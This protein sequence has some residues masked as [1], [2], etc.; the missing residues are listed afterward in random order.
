MVDPVPSSID[1]HPTSPDE[2]AKSLAPT[3]AEHALKELGMKTA[4]EAVH[5]LDVGVTT[6]DMTTG[7]MDGWKNGVKIPGA[8]YY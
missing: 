8:G 2:L 3:A 1:H 7:A 4:A 5:V 6:Y